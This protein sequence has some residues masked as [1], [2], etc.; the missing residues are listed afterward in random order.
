MSRN[1]IPIAGIFLA[2]VI[3]AGIPAVAAADQ[4]KTTPVINPVPVVTTVQDQPES[5]LEKIPIQPVNATQDKNTNKIADTPADKANQKKT[6][7]TADKPAAVTVDK[8]ISQTTNVADDQ[9]SW[10][11]NLWPFGQ[12]KAEEN[13]TPVKETSQ[14]VEKPVTST[15]PAD[16]DQKSTLKQVTDKTANK[17]NIPVAKTP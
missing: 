3:A 14:V 17:E 4:T 2:C 16:N 5:P 11:E 12:V 10:W 8:V 15:P 13:K 6:D 1:I 9:K 7:T